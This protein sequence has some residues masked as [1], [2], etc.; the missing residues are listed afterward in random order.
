MSS[1]DE[2]DAIIVGGGFYGYL[3]AIHL[4]KSGAARV[5]LMERESS[6][7]LRASPSR[8]LRTRDCSKASV[9]SPPRSDLVGL[10]MW[11]LAATAI[12]PAHHQTGDRDQ[13]APPGVP[14][15]LAME[16]TGG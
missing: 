10:A 12:R 1:R 6:I 5:L 9:G 8:K 14:T 16:V 4:R 15:L 3:L 2:Y 7:L 13:M 11:D